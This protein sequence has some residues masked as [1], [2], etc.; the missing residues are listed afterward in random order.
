MRDFIKGLR[1]GTI[2]HI[3]TVLSK[4][5]Y[6]C[7]ITTIIQENYNHNKRKGLTMLLYVHQLQF[8][9]LFTERKKTIF[10]I[11]TI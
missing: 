11:K 1:K 7:I 9:G 4:A 6:S 2:D 5:G 10:V 3:N 8:A